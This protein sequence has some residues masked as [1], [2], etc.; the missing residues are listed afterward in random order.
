[1]SGFGHA[2]GVLGVTERQLRRLW[3]AYRRHGA[4]HQFQ[5]TPYEQ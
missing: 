3:T 2:L 4:A 5:V 1:M